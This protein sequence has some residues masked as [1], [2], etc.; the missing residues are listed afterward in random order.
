MTSLVVV[1]E[2]NIVFHATSLQFLISQLFKDN[3]LEV[4][5]EE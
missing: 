1:E 2:T 4:F 5:L 3:G